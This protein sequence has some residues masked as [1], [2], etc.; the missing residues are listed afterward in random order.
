[1]SD[2]RRAFLILFSAPCVAGLVAPGHDWGR[3]LIAAAVYIATAC[4][5]IPWRDDA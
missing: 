3:Q 1:M 5:L 4:A 2:A